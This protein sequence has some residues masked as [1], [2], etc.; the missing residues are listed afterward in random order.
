MEIQRIGQRKVVGIELPEGL[1]LHND[2]GH[3][4]HTVVPY[5]RVQ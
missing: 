2:T 5:H 4:I 1:R 3:D